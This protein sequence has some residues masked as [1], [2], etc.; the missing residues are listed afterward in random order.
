M[1]FAPDQGHQHPASEAALSGSA[2]ASECRGAHSTDVTRPS[3]DVNPDLRSGI[4]RAERTSSARSW[5]IP[6]RTTSEASHRRLGSRPP[7]ESERLLRFAPASFLLV[8]LV[9]GCSDPVDPAP[10]AA[11]DRPESVSFF[12]WDNSTG[13][14][15]PLERC[16]PMAIPPED[17][18]PGSPP[19]PFELHSAVT[20]T[21]TGEV[22]AVQVTG[23]DDDPAG[24]IDSDVRV[25]GFTFA[26]VGDLPSAVVTP[27]LDPAFTYV[28]SRGSSSL[29]VIDTTSFRNGLGVQVR[30]IP[31][32]GDN[33]FF[34]DLEGADV[35]PGR[36]SAMVL[37]EAEDELIVA[38]PELG[39]VWFVPID[40]DVVGD[41][42]RL[43]LSSDV[44]APV[45]LTTAGAQP[46]DYQV[47]CPADL[48]A[49]DPTLA[50]P[51]TPV[52]SGAAPRP[53]ALAVDE[54]LGQVI[55]A[56]RALPILHVIDL[57]T[58][59]ELAA[60]NVGV[61]TRDVVLTPFVPAERGDTERTE[62]FIYAIDELNQSVLAVDYSDPARASFGAVLSVNAGSLPD[63][64]AVPLP[65]RAIEVVAPAWTTDGPLPA[66]VADA[67]PASLRGVFLA[68]ATT[69]G[70]VRIFDVFDLNAPCRLTECGAGN[71]PAD[72]VAIRR[73]RP[74]IAGFQEDGVSVEPAPSW[75]INGAT[76]Q[77][78]ED[79]GAAGDGLSTLEPVQENPDAAE[80]PA[81]L[82]PV[83][84]E[85]ARICAVT[86]PW[87]AT[88]QRYDVAW[89]GAL[90]NTT[91]TGAT[92]DPDEPAIDVRFDPCAL[93]AL[94]SADVPDS[95]PLANYAGDA[96]AITSPLAPA[97]ADDDLCERITQENDA[98]ETT[99]ILFPLVSASAESERPSYGGR[100]V[101]GESAINVDATLAD[102]RTC[103]PELLEI[104]LRTRGA[105][106]VTS[107]RAGFRSPV[108]AGADGTCEVDPAALAAGNSGRALPGQLF[109]TPEVAFFLE[110]VPPAQ[111]TLTFTTANV[112]TPL[113]FDISFDAANDTSDI[114]LLAALEFNEIDDR[115]YVVDQARRGLVRVNLE[116]GVIET[117]FQ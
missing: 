4:V 117:F 62:R 85:P 32:E 82:G 102:V 41:P 12:C 69:D 73:H 51:R 16:A 26:P 98:G 44:P 39:E 6:W 108:V 18:T 48:P 115:L 38:V 65:A 10:P 72:F 74:R 103:F 24:V 78:D 1:R 33:A 76:S 83:F 22:A 7:R 15:V 25:P 110:G 35:T 43:P 60:I 58:R 54:E 105:F 59:A 116:S 77:V 8:G 89:E 70:R 56:D 2:P 46:P 97:R 36:P 27:S 53:W 20:Q 63:R 95:G 101:I 106:V 52:S 107:S 80:C 37:N 93:G 100:L 9:L 75:S 47:L 84:G 68:V 28:I 19:E 34:V 5:T 90:P 40:G 30:P 55:V 94:G 29:H 99:P 42:V 21:A 91:M 57:E 31:G 113:S 81:G 86:D 64:L 111:A 13:M 61:P 50:P 109:Q 92:F 14:P 112:P 23:D 104:E 49:V 67:S 71:D 45:D 11:F 79:T 88:S 17:A 66:C 87:E 96:V 114:S 3:A